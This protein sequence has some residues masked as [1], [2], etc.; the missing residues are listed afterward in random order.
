MREEKKMKE[1]AEKALV[2]HEPEPIPTSHSAVDSGVTDSATQTTIKASGHD[3]DQSRPGSGKGGSADQYRQDQN[4]NNHVMKAVS[5]PMP[6]RQYSH[7]R[8]PS[9]RG[10]PPLEGAENN[11]KMVTDDDQKL[12]DVLRQESQARPVR[13]Q[14]SSST[15]SGSESSEEESTSD[16]ENTSEEDQNE[17]EK[18]MTAIGAGV[19]KV[20][21][22]FRHRSE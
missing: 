11:A 18:R 1:N 14:S 6:S 3:R 20:T 16:G 21:A 7:H 22:S 4:M 2:S 19:E 9:L 10:G 5:V 12:E 15:S 17:D 8:K 13:S